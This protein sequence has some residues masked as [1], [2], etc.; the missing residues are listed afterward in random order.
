MAGLSGIFMAILGLVALSIAIAPR[1]ASIS[2]ELFSRMRTIEW[3]LA[4]VFCGLG[5]VI[6]R[7]SIAKYSNLP[8]DTEVQKHE[9]YTV[10]FASV[11]IL[12]LLATAIAVVSG[13]VNNQNRP[14][15]NDFRHIGP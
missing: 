8:K 5:M 1:P 3:V 14:I 6:V 13:T 2:A 15:S 10:V 7:A 4:A 11:A 12:G 9:A